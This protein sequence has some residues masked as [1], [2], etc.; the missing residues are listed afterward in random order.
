MSRWLDVTAAV[1]AFISAIFWFLSAAGRLPPMVAYWD[2]TPPTDP[3]FSAVRFSARMNTVAAI[4]SGISAVL[5]G[6][7]LIFFPT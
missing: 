2:S 6:V 4:A 1:F 7:R 3:F 5:I